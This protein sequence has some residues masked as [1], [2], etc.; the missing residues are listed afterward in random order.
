MNGEEI[1]TIVFI[2]EPLELLARQ[3]QFAYSSLWKIKGKKKVRVG[4]KIRE[5]TRK[6]L[7]IKKD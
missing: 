7:E 1:N 5:I 4:N 2:S 6:G 3:I